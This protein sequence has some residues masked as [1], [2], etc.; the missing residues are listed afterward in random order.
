MSVMRRTARMAPVYKGR[1]IR[2]PS[3]GILYLFPSLMLFL[4]LPDFPQV[5]SLLYPVTLCPTWSCC[6]I[7]SVSLLFS[8][9]LTCSR[10]LGGLT[11][12]LYPDSLASSSG[13]TRT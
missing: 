6:L 2:R 7:W 12:C 8:L 5:L 13:N 11:L 4:T 1:Y 3:P 9:I 10:G